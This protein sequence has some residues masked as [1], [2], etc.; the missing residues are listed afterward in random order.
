MCNVDM[1]CGT[2]TQNSY[3]YTLNGP[4][5]QTRECSGMGI[6]VTHMFSGTREKD[7]GV[8]FLGRVNSTF[9]SIAV[10]QMDDGRGTLVAHLRSRGQ[11]TQVL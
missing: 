5:S 3:M 7:V 4:G 2:H 1:Q 11:V 10:S 8:I 9:V 6:P